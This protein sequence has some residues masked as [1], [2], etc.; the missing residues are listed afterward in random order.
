MV[1]ICADS[2]KKTHTLVAVDAVGRRLGVKTVRTNSEGHLTLVEWAAHF[3][4]MDDH[5]VV[6]ALEDCQHRSPTCWPPA[7][8]SYACPPG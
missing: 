2:H 1:M 4:G 3:D 5:G 7:T 6:F 8:A